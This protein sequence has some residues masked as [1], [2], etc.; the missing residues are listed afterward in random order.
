MEFYKLLQEHSTF[1]WHRYK[2]DNLAEFGRVG[3]RCL[4]AETG[5]KGF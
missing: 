5:G 3:T 4:Q 2:E 1:V